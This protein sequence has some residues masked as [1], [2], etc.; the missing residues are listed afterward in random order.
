[1]CSWVGLSEKLS[2]HCVE[3]CIL[4]L[5]LPCK[6]WVPHRQIPDVF[7]AGA[8]H[9]VHCPICR[10]QCAA[11]QRWRFSSWNRISQIKI[12]YSRI[13]SQKQIALMYL[14][15]TGSDCWF[16]K[17]WN[18]KQNWYLTYLKYSS[19]SFFIS[20]PSNVCQNDM[21]GDWYQFLV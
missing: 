21:P 10:V 13:T 6:Y 7:S 3:I 17:P 1:M 16:L 18:D 11:C 5:I 8:V 2:G 9:S 12:I 4:R 20:P 19:K 14:I 15:R